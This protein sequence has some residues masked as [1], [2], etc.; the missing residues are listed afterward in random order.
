MTRPTQRGRL[1]QIGCCAAVAA[2][3]IAGCRQGNKFVEPPPPTVTV[4]HPIERPV[5][6]SI[7]FVGS[8]QATVTV[9]LRARVP[10]YLERIE[11]K[12]GSN[13]KAGD[14]L[15]VIE[16]AP[17]KLSLASKKAA[18]QKAISSQALAESQLRRMEKA[19]ESGAVTQEELDI[20]AA[21]VATS[22]ADVA[23]AESAVEQ[24]ELDLGY[25]R[26]L[27]PIDGRIN[28]HL[29]DIGNLIQAQ[30]T[31]LALIQSIDPIHAYFDVSENDLLRFM[32]MLR[33]QKLPDP[34]KNPPVL[35]LGLANEKGFPHEGKL[36]YRELNINQATGTARRRGIF[37]NPERQ[38]IPGMFVRIQA[39]VGEPQPRLL[40]D[41]RAIGTDQRGDYVLVVNDKNVVE[42]RT[43]RLGIHADTMRVIDEGINKDNWIVING[44][45][46]ARPGA[47]VAPER[48]EMNTQNEPAIDKKQNKPKSDSSAIKTGTTEAQKK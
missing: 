24:A 23:S 7:E 33:K 12:D 42:Y 3:L 4:A 34:E 22:K 31:P 30:Q 1:F 32:D 20:Q 47:K 18:L 44:L 43:V 29:V 9:D 14:L 8:T 13:V 28:R 45:Q 5:A 15:F 46:R 41:E 17:Y 36:D 40:V 10:G 6:D 25:T 38:L 11:F 21:Q 48:A 19:A 35:H 16:Q 27:A 37:P 39:S 2:V 26:I